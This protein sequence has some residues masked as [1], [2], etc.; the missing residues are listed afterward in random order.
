LVVIGVIA[1]LAALLLPALSGA[2]EKARSVQCRNNER[3]IG[4][5]FRMLIDH[6][7]RDAMSELWRHGDLWWKT[8]VAPGEA[9][10]MCP[11]APLRRQPAHLTIGVGFPGTA[12]S[13]WLMKTND[14]PVPGGLASDAVPGLD[15]GGF[16]FNGHLLWPD[17]LDRERFVRPTTFKSEGDI[18]Y[19]TLTPV[20]TDAGFPKVYPGAMDGLPVNLYYG[21]RVSGGGIDS[22]SQMQFV[23]I[24]RHGHRAA[25]PLGRFNPQHPLQG[26]VNMAFFDGHAESVR[27]E[28]LWH[29]YWHKDY[30]PPAK[31]PGLK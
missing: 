12:G 10:R 23:G 9:L 13:A 17:D 20:V 24:A 2:K 28:R 16:A 7:L 30:V 1:I 21:V 22:F 6:G 4:L 5:N 3:Q 25:R 14:Q 18:L 27:L 15:A 31:R 19:P 29:L 11:S 8:S 26:S